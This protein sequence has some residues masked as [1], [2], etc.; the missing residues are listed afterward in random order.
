MGRVDVFVHVVWST[1]RRQPLIGADVEPLLFGALRKKCQELR[2]APIAV[3]GTEDHVHLV[4]R[5]H[6]LVS[7]A[8]LV[9]EVKGLSSF[10]MSREFARDRFFRWQDGY[11]ATSLA[12][13]DVPNLERYVR[14]QKIHHATAHLLP[15]FEAP[16]E[17]S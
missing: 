2:C 6:P 17:V 7:I 8:V 14:D 3:G 5:V 10:L 16:S 11:L 13:D 15:D 1:W 4:T 9:K 12:P